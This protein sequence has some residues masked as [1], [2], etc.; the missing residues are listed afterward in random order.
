MGVSLGSEPAMVQ[1][2][3]D[4]SAVTWQSADAPTFG[5]VKVRVWG[6]AGGVDVRTR[7]R[8]GAVC[9]SI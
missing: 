1:L 5:N 4:Q 7:G 6:G 9:S 3:E 2:S 8:G